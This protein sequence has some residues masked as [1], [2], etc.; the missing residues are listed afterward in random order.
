[1]SRF[2]LV[3]DHAVVRRGVRQIIG[4]AFPDSVF[5]EAASGPEAVRMVEEGDWDLA[6]LD[7]ALPG[8]S[9]LDV[10]KE[11]RRLRPKLPVLILS[12]YPSDQYATRV[13]RAGAAGYL[14]KESVPEVLTKAVTRILEGRTY[15][16]EDV[17]E[18][19]ASQIREGGDRPLYES[20]SDREYEVLRLLGQGLLVSEVAD[21]LKLSVKT[22]STYR[23]RLLSKLGLE[24]SAQLIRYALDHKLVD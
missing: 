5:G 2:L 11:V 15:I 8:R 12:I 4:D 3:D 9:G 21:H 20:L 24:T 14:T 23:S 22:I 16:G 7:I 6:V 10:L 18:R 1:M 19:L 17:A 13:L